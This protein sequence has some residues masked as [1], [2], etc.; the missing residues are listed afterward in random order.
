MNVENG[1]EATQFLFWEYLFGI[2]GIMSLQC[3]LRPMVK[4]NLLLT[5]LEMGRL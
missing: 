4:E 5:T 1:T 2:F 3:E